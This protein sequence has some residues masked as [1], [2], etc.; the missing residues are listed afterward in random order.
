MSVTVACDHLGIAQ[1]SDAL[2]LPTIDPGSVQ[3]KDPTDA[4]KRPAT[5]YSSLILEPS[6]GSEVPPCG[7]V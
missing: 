7:Q 2:K 5:R 4:L 3:R 1:M 6:S